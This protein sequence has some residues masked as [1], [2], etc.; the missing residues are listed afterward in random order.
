MW[1]PNLLKPMLINS[2]DSGSL[3]CKEGTNKDLE[4]TYNLPIIFIFFAITLL[5]FCINVPYAIYVFYKVRCCQMD[6]VG[7]VQLS[8]II[9]TNIMFTVDVIL[10]LMKIDQLHKMLDLATSG[11]NAVI[12][13]YIFYK[14]KVVR[15]WLE[16]NHPVQL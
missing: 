13:F 6:K 7:I 11:I 8:L 12:L 14:I 5:S 1:E 16:S 10:S 2:T 3:N 15:I 4:C 9:F